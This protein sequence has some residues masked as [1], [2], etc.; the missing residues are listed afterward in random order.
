MTKARRL[1]V[2]TPVL[3][4]VDSVHHTLT[5]EFIEGRS[6]KD[7]LLEFGSNGVI[8]E[9]LYDIATQIGTAIAKLHDGGLV[10]GDLT[11]SNMIV[12]EGTNQ[13]VRSLVFHVCS[14]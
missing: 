9:R 8:E 2:V 4:G 5:F 11:T 3:Y 14:I 12:K 1:G 7:V 13:V 10:H 6:V